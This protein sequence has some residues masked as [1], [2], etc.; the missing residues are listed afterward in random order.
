MTPASCVD[1]KYS[2]TATSFKFQQ[3]WLPPSLTHYTVSQKNGTLF[4][5]STT[6]ANT[7]RLL[8]FHYCRQKL[9]TSKCT[10]KSTTVPKIC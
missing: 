1:S 4:H 6:L 2:Y 3:A 8:F 5:L 9:T 7:V 10:I